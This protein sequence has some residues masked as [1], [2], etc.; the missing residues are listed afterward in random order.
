MA[1]NTVISVQVCYMAPEIQ[2]LKT[3]QVT[4][5]VTLHQ[6][7]QISGLLEVVA[8]L[9]LSHAKVGIYSKL[10]TLDT[11]LKANDRVEVYRPLQVDPMVARRARANKK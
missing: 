4:Q 10:K 8:G 2:F 3:L 1:S 7:V 9:D 6:A 11:V 5:G